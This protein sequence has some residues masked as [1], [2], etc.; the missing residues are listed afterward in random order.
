MT[1]EEARAALLRH[2]AVLVNVWL[3]E[4]R[5]PTAREKL[6]GLVFSILVIMDGESGQL[7]GFELKPVKNDDGWPRKDI[8]GCLH[9]QWHKF[10]PK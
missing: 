6:S 9:D 4:S 7:P 2:V 5:A 1:V 3:N 10:D 8:A